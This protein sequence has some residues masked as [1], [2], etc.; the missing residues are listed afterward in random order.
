MASAKILGE[1]PLSGSDEAV[2]YQTWGVLVVQ[3]GYTTGNAKSLCNLS[4][5]VWW[6][7]SDKS[8]SDCTDTIFSA[9]KGISLI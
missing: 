3:W 1:F 2:N 6:E 9:K 5:N 7:N 4:I 8:A